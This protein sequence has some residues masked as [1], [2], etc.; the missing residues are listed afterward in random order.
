MKGIK[1]T[2]PAEDSQLYLTSQGTGAS[3]LKVLKLSSVASRINQRF[4]EQK[5]KGNDGQICVCLRLFTCVQT[6]ELTHSQVAHCV[7]ATDC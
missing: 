1:L 7:M 3:E 4:Q 5:L 6:T 2:I